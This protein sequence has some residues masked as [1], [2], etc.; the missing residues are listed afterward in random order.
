MTERGESRIEK[1]GWGLLEE[2]GAGAC[3]CVGTRRGVGFF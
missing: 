3:G 1:G 2:E